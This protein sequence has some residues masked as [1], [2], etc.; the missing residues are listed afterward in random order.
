[1]ALY[2][3]LASHHGGQDLKLVR[4]SDAEAEHLPGGY[5]W[6]GWS[7]PPP[8]DQWLSSR[9]LSSHWKILPQGSLWLVNMRCFK[10]H[11]FY[12]KPLRKLDLLWISWGDNYGIY[13]FWANW[14]ASFNPHKNGPLHAL[15]Q[16]GQKY[17]VSLQC[18]PPV[19]SKILSEDTNKMSKSQQ[20]FDTT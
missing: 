2:W 16:N 10:T 6:G 1:M 4:K 19:D 15:M 12:A 9:A 18:L 14:I 3:V 11:F 17:V 20:L 7:S 8:A 5:R 13:D